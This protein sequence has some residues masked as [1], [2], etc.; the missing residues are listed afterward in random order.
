MASTKEFFK[1]KKEWSNYKDALLGSYILP[2]FNKIMSTGVEVVYI[3]GFAGKGKFDDGTPG[4]PL[5][6]K[7]K[8]Y[9]A[10]ANSKFNTKITPYFVEYEHADILRSNLCDVSMNVVQGDYRTEVPKI[11]KSNLTKNIFLYVD[12]FGIKYLDFSIF[13]QLTPRKYNSVELLLNFNSFGF[14]REGCRLL[15]LNMEHID[16]ELPEFTIDSNDFKNDI[17]NM[18]R[19]ANGDYWQAI[20]ADYNSG[21]IDIFQAEKLFLKQYMKELAK[22]FNFVCRIPIRYSKSRLSKYQM[23][24]ATNNKHGIIL[25]ADNM[26]ACN[27]QMT[28]DINKGQP[29]L[30]DYEYRVCDCESF[31][32]SELPDE[33]IELKDFYSTLYRKK[34]F[35]YL[36]KDMNNAIK[37]LESNGQIDIIRVP[38]TTKTGRI[39]KSMNFYQNT[40][41]IKR[42]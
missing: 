16:D 30:F 1:K 25:M 10:K 28:I 36:T 5:L 7:E 22:T 9:Q 8:V 13:S 31:I 37:N 24:F 11:L 4:S 34:G 17:A 29:C 26:I 15:K 39:S 42:K 18:N 41:K 23:L 14:L 32:K 12:P 6:V 27:N 19:I 2:Y 35:L 21:K 20:L 3:D 38:A 40:I 33:Y